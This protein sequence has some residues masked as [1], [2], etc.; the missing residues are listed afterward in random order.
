[1]T[2]ET[3]MT[4]IKEISGSVQSGDTRQT[5]ELTGR[6]IS[7]NCHPF[8]ILR[9]GLIA[10]MMEMERKFQR[11]EILDSELLIAEQT[12]KAGLT[13]LT[14]ALEAVRE[15]PAGTVIAGTPE[16]DIRE[17]EKNI[18]SVLMQNMGLKVTDLGTSVSNVQFI[19]AA[20]E[21]RAAIIVCTTSLTTFL[22]RMKSLVQ[23][24]SQANIRSKTKL[25]FT[26]RPVTEWFCKSVE[27]DLYAPDPV[28]AAEIAADYCRRKLR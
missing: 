8:T 16:G 13:I 18:I 17:T 22:A 21:E 11:N 2:E 26:G 1:M 12:M 3:N 6:A 27:A 5:V 4:Y 20:M 10:G 9:E 14:P 28:Q 24:A 15:E 7:E 25:L 19:E 23:A